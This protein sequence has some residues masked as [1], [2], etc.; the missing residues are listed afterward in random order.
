MPDAPNERL[1]SLVA[2]LGEDDVRD[3]VRLFLESYPGILLEIASGDR[4]RSHRAAHNLKSSSQQMGVPA[5]AARMLQLEHRLA[6]PGGVVTPADLD[7]IAADFAQAEGA[8]RAF[9]G[10][11]ASSP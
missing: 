10:P 7:G 8:L 1:A 11:G 4:S 6:N 9:A 5:L 2:V 3:L